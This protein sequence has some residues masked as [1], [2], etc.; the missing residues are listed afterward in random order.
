MVSEI[1]ELTIANKEK[2]LNEPAE[3][4][5]ERIGFVARGISIEREKIQ[6]RQ[7]IL[8][9]SRDKSAAADVFVCFVVT[10]SM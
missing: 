4:K 1:T 8:E 2:R 9:C 3:P 7:S 5:R 10:G 6:Y